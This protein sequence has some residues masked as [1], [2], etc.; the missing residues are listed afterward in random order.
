MKRYSS[1]FIFTVLFNLNWA[2]CAYMYVPFTGQLSK[3]RIWH[4]NKFLG[5]SW[6][7]ESVEV[8][9]ETTNNTYQFPCNKWLSKD[10]DDKSLLREIPCANTK[11]NDNTHSTSM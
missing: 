9:D 7:L 10:K 3:V 2:L 1:D 4:D 5:A 11:T 8:V 6:F